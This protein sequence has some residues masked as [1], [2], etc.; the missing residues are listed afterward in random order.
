LRE[1]ER[2][3]VPVTDLRALVLDD[4]RLNMNLVYC[5]MEGFAIAPDGTLYVLDECG[6]FAYMDTE[7]YKVEWIQEEE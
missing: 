7:R 1:A 2:E 4:D 5:D 6:N 3:S